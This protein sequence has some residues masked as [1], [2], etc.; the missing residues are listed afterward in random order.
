MRVIVVATRRFS[1]GLGKIVGNFR[2]GMDRDSIPYKHF[3]GVLRTTAF[4]AG[5][6]AVTSCSMTAILTAKTSERVRDARRRRRIPF[7]FQRTSLAGLAPDSAT[8]SGLGRAPAL[9]CRTLSRHHLELQGRRDYTPADKAKMTCWLG[10]PG[11]LY[12]L[13]A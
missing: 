8:I 12:Y 3:A 4:I 5:S 11:L 6:N 13:A 9:Q 2:E 10:F 1:E 7:D